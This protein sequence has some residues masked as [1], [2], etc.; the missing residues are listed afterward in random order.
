MA[1]YGLLGQPEEDALHKSRLLNVEEKPFKRISKRLL[2]PDSLIVSRSSLPLTP[3]PEETDADSDATATE[4]EKQK[5][6]E[7]W[8]HFREDVA[9][10]FATFEGSIARV[11]FLLTSNEQER[12]RYA[13]ERVQILSTMQSV[14]ESTADLRTQL[15]EARRLL[16]LRKTYDELTDKITSNRL[17]KPREDQSAN[18]QK[19]R[20]EIADLEKESKDYAM[21][22]AER[23][24][25]F[26]RIVDEGMQLRRLIRD[27]KE[28][29]ERREGMQ[30]GEDGDEGDVTSKGKASSGNTPPGPENDA[31]TPSQHGQD[32]A[33][34]PSGLQVQKPGAA[35]AASP[36]RQ[37]TTAQGDGAR[38]DTNMLDEGEISAVSDGEL[39]E[40]EEGEELPDDFSGKM[41][42]T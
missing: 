41:D 29:V 17:L 32:D 6:L 22:W 11:Q 42:T 16:S 8:H 27:E 10:D 12:Q 4:A 31:M 26:G 30:E 40:L 19:L 5:R 1:S 3:P 21:T 23:R 28:E 13:T 38:E 2:N 39:S 20:L 34:R 36:L 9:L 14:R 35:G 18:L 15:E 7:E 25:Q 33:G 24:E 37:V